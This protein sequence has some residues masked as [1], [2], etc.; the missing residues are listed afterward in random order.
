[1]RKNRQCIFQ[2]FRNK[3]I[4]FELLEMV[5]QDKINGFVWSNSNL[6]NSGEETACHINTVTT[7]FCS[8]SHRNES[9][10]NISGYIYHVHSNTLTDAKTHRCCVHMCEG[11]CLS[12]HFGCEKTIENSVQTIT[13]R[14]EKYMVIHAFLKDN[15]INIASSSRHTRFSAPFASTH[16][17]HH[18]YLL[19]TP[20]PH[21]ANSF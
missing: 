15:T 14:T 16:A 11:R 19:W 13:N 18:H 5:I 3:F 1:M 21:V 8:Q 10:V 12:S 6:H 7:Y 17:N 4:E 9:V 2:D 20:G